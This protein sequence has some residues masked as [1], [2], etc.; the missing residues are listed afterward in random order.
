MFDCEYSMA[1]TNA[2]VFLSGVDEGIM[3]EHNCY[4]HGRCGCLWST[5]SCNMAVNGITMNNVASY[6]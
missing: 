6:V 2:S 3:T 1:V 5:T 4:G